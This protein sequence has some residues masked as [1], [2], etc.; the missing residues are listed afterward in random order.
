MI[1]QLEKLA[2]FLLFLLSPED[3]YINPRYFLSHTFPD[4]RRIAEVG[5]GVVTVVG[6][7]AVTIA[8]EA[9]TVAGAGAVTIARETDLNR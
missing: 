1:I 6:T 4:S 5:T 3:V 9:V 2:V 8:E 7:I